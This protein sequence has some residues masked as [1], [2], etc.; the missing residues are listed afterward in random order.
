MAG[1]YALS[2]SGGPKSPRFAAYTARVE[3]E[4]GLSGYNPM[5]GPP[6]LEA[7]RHLLSLDA[8]TIAAAAAAAVAARCEFDGE[9]TLAIVVASPGMWTDRLA[10]EVQHRTLAARRP[11]HGEILLWNGDVIDVELV[12]QES[13]AETVRTMWT[14]IHGEATTLFGVLSR[15][16]LAYA[17]S[18]NPYGAISPD[19]CATVEDAL[20]I[21]GDTTTQGDI[22]AV[23]YG[24]PAATALGWTTLGIPEHA[25]FR[26]AIARATELIARIGPRIALSTRP[27]VLLSSRT[28]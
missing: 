6:A 5:A 15:E 11:A 16:G 20:S 28:Q 8:E 18:S 10:T 25:G 3:H 2:R 7:V 23:L 17:L 27:P 22:A 13:A 9:L 12:Q 26:W 14:S 21:L 24:D 4:W 1:L 19:D